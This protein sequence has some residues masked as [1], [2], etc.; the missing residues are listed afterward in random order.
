MYPQCTLTIHRFLLEW[1]IL[2][3]LYFHSDGRLHGFCAAGTTECADN[4]TKCENGVCNCEDDYSAIDG[5]CK[6]GKKN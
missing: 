3:F 1:I 5:T 2:W 6:Q 4:N